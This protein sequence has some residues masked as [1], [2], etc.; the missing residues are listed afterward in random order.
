ML[1]VLGFSTEAESTGD[2]G[3]NRIYYKELVHAIMEAEK[4]NKSEAQEASGIV[5]RT[6]GSM[7]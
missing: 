5:L 3:Y 2:V 4:S 1:M 6:G 7:V